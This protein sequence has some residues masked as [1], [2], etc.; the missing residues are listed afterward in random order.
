MAKEYAQ[1]RACAGKRVP[2]L[3]GCNNSQTC[4]SVS[5]PL[6]SFGSKGT[7]LVR[8]FNC[9]N[10]TG[11]EPLIGDFVQALVTYSLT[12][13]DVSLTITVVFYPNIL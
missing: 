2:C 3:S 5:G 12:L 11:L 9:E 8:A 10:G 13:C 6:T 1:V 4:G 7:E